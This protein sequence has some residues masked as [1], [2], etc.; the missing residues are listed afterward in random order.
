MCGIFLYIQKLKDIETKKIKKID[1]SFKRIQKRGPDNS[2]LIK[3][4]KMIMGFHRLCIMDRSILGNQPFKYHNMTLICNG[5]IFNYN[6]IIEEFKFKCF[7]KSDCEVILHLYEFY[8]QEGINNNE[9]MYKLCNK[10]D[11]EFVFCLNDNNIK[12][13]FIARDP[14]GVRPLFYNHDCLNYIIFASEMKGLY[15][16]SKNNLNHIKQFQPGKYMIYDNNKEIIISYNKYIKDLLLIEKVDH[17]EEEILKNINKIFKEAVYKR[18]MS[19]REICCLLSGGLDSSLVASI[20]CSQFEPNTVKT[21]SIG[22]KGSPDLYY[23]QIVADHIKSNH[24]L[25]E[26]TEEDFLNSIEETIKVIESYDITSVRASVGNYL[27]SKYIK[28]NSNC[29]VVFNGDYSDEV[30]GGYIYFN[31][32]DDPNEFNIETKRLVTDICYFDSLRSDR[33]VSQNGL[34]AR[35]P[36]ADKKFIEYI[37]SINPELKIAKTNN[38]VEKYL[39]R[40]AFAN[41]NLLP[42]EILWRQKEAFSDGVTSQKR[43]WYQIIQEYVDTQITDEEFNTNKNDFLINKPMT[44]EAYYYRKIYNK[45]YQ[46]TDQ[47]IP[48]FWLPKYS[49]GATD[50]SARTLNNYKN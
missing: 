3:K 43:S 28:E 27:V 29:K 41:D 50:P 8:K 6:E 48:Y 16:L 12:K 15:D 13:T 33:S 32:C 26:L 1:K 25:I 7:S 47:V 30:L 21:Y 4:R 44:K 18:I 22:I 46:Y 9:I 37:F 24:T 34:E 10:L 20:V 49:N 19:D 2:K 14:Y 35:V 11:G 31:K 5:E 42:D 23:S 40:K 38:Y 39:L 45:Y 17:K 36:F